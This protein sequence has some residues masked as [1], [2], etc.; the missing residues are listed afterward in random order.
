MTRL[1]Q[2]FFAAATAGTRSSGPIFH[3]H[4]CCP[5]FRRLDPSNTAFGFSRGTVMHLRLL[6]WA[7]APAGLA[8]VLLAGQTSFTRAQTTTGTTGMT[9]MSVDAAINAAFE[10]YRGLQE[11]KNADY[12]PALAKVN[13]NLYGIA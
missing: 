11:G 7:V 4:V 2:R 10:K 3:R 13:P 6:R 1:G 5:L 9:A 8:L 12:I